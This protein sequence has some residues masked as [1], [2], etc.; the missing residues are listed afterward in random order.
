[1]HA[2][3][4]YSTPEGCACY[5]NDRVQNLCGQHVIKGGMIGDY[6]LVLIYDRAF[7]EMYFG[8]D[9]VARCVEGSV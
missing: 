8:K 5:P 3:G 9:V 7:Y 2:V 1:M 4:Q 6:A